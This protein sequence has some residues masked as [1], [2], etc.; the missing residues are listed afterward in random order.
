[1]FA[2]FGT[3]CVGLIGQLA[4]PQTRLYGLTYFF[5]F[6]IAAGVFSA[7]TFIITLTANNLA[8]SSKRAVG[9]GLILSF[10]AL[11]G[12]C[13]SNIFILSQAPKF[14]TGFGTALGMEVAAIISAIVLR[15]MLV[16]EN[17]KRD[18]FMADKTVEDVK[19]MYT[20]QEL[21]DLG[22]RSPLFRY[23]L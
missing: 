16:S 18:D 22:D 6:P 7:P 17:K 13:G 23:T 19:A 2:A 15:R 5:L 3:A 9:L 11:G 1:M 21:L 12:I 4:I 8:P 10:S 20:E 14:P